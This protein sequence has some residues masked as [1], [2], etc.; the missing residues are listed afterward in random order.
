MAWVC[1]RSKYRGH[2]IGQA[3]A[4][5]DCPSVVHSACQYEATRHCQIQWRCDRATRPCTCLRIEYL[6]LLPFNETKL[7]MRAAQQG[8][9]A[10]HQNFALSLSECCLQSQPESLPIYSFYQDQTSEPRSLHTLDHLNLRVSTYTPHSHPPHPISQ[11]PHHSITRACSMG[12][13][14]RQRHV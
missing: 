13:S 7:S 4:V 6:C 9:D 11:N 3:H 10:D 2:D 5:A 8:P 1:P 12:L 14:G